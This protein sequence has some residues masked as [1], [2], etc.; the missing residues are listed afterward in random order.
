MMYPYVKY[1]DGTEVVFSHIMK[2]ENGE[3]IMHVHFERPTENGFDSVR[4]EL[5]SCKVLYKDGN[6]SEKEIEFFKQVVQNSADL[7]YKYAKEGGLKR[8]TQ[9]I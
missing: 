8:L 3:E 1:S 2:N 5:P 7:F 6:Y 4:F 9:P